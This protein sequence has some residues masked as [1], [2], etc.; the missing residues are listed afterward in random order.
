[1]KQFIR[2]ICAKRAGERGNDK[3]AKPNTDQNSECKRFRTDRS[4]QNIGQKCIAS[5]SPLSLLKGE[6]RMRVRP[7]WVIA[8]TPHLIP[9][10]FSKGRG[11][12][13][14]AVWKVDVHQKFF[15]KCIPAY[16]CVAGF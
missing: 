1:M 5:P 9:L 11:G 13:R 14:R 8:E 16:I 3:Q 15:R 2:R 7:R 4:D 10:P 12:R 6:D